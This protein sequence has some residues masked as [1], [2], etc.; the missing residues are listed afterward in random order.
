MNGASVAYSKE[1][2]KI[3]VNVDEKIQI[4]YIEDEKDVRE[5]ISLRL[6]QEDCFVESASTLEEAHRMIEQNKY[7]VVL[8]DIMF[9][10]SPISGDEFI[11]QSRSLLKHSKIIAF[12]G[13]EG[14]IVPE[15]RHLFDRI[16]RKG[17]SGELFIGLSLFEKI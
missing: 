7:D 1:S 15:N 10:S 6:L 17:T 9:D 4:L 3:N 13:Y 11:R 2:K 12:T 16:I 8:T 14:Q 5:T